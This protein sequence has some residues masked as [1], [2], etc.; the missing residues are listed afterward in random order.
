MISRATTA[1]AMAIAF[2]AVL[3][4][5]IVAPKYLTYASDPNHIGIAQAAPTWATYSALLA[6]LCLGFCYRALYAPIGH[7]LAPTGLWAFVGFLLVW[8]VGWG[9]DPEHLAG[10]LQLL[11]GVFA[12]ILGAYLGRRMMTELKAVRLVSYAVLGIVILEVGVMAAQVAGV[13]L[14]PMDPSVA[15]LMG[16]RVNGTMNHPNNIGKAIFLLMVLALGL[17]GASDA[18]VRRAS[19]SAVLLSM[20]PLALSQGRANLLAGVLLVVFWALLQPRGRPMLA[21]VGVPIAVFFLVAPFVPTILE[22]LAS[23]PEGGER[24]RLA[25]VAIEQ[26]QMRPFWG[27]GPNAY[28]STASPFD[29]VVASG[30]SVHNA[31]LLTAAE[32]GLIG[33]VLFWAPVAQLLLVCARSRKR[34][35]FASSFSIAMLASVPGMYFILSTG[36]TMLS[37]SLLPLWFLIY[38]LA[39]SQVVRGREPRHAPVGSRGGERSLQ[40][41]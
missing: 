6:I 2:C 35:G 4:A 13:P 14:N 9:I 11:S 38:G 41:V 28:V 7:R 25:A 24:P 30:Y 19:W 16:S 15:E 37:A 10:L 1:Y 40:R 12:W 5:S 33:A 39:F 21:R 26:I 20:L 18:R 34:P 36:W 31:F 8:T 3:F 22:R 29:S 23:D 27:T 32:L 17:V